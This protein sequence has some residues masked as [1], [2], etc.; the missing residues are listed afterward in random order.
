MSNKPDSGIYNLGTGQARS[1][2]DLAVSTFSAL[3]LEP[4]IEFIDT[5][6]DIRDKY[7]YF[8]EADMTKMREAG[9]QG[10]FTSLEEG[11]K[12]YVSNYLINTKYF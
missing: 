1:F 11:V 3:N 9:Y 7:Q 12:D 2:Y 8:T 10:I 4:V 5:P 6:I